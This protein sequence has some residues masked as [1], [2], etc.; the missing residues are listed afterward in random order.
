[1]M[2][3]PDPLWVGFDPATDKPESTTGISFDWK[4]YSKVIDAN[5]SVKVA[6]SYSEG[7]HDIL[8]I[9]AVIST[10]DSEHILTDMTVE[11]LA[12]YILEDIESGDFIA[13]IEEAY[14]AQEAKDSRA[15]TH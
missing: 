5:I 7:G 4:G 3:A 11:A 9:A 1:M 13:K 6:G 2:D 8:S 14:I 12:K 10:R 15:Y